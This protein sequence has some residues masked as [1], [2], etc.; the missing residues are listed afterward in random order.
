MSTK[1]SI[2]AFG[3]HPDDIEFGCGGVIVR[4]TRAG[5]HAH[6]VVCSRGESA[7]NGTPAERTREAQKGAKLLGATV[8]FLKLDGDCRLEARPANALAVAVILRR[9]SP[10]VVLAPTVV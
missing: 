3:A 6:F 2:L 7:T 4:E 9:F 1:L 10:S 8:A 5:N